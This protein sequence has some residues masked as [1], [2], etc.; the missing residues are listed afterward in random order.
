MTN[1]FVSGA[2]TEV[3]KTFVTTMLIN[4]IRKNDR[5]VMA[6]KPVISG[7]V[8]DDVGESDTGQILEALGLEITPDNI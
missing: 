6:L 7:F 3:G 1:L 8:D 5:P 2:G 4:E